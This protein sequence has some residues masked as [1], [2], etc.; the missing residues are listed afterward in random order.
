MK[1][2][3]MLAFIATQLLSGCA[4][5]SSVHRTLDTT[6]GQGVL[7]DIKQRAIL[8]SNRKITR[9]DVETTQTVVCAEPSPDALSAYAL[10]L[11]AKA[12]DA[13]GK[14]ISVGMGSS[15]SSAYV[16]LRTQSIQLLRD[17]FFRACEAYMNNAIDAGEYNLLI[18]RYQK[19]TAALL[20]IEQL[21]TIVSVPR[22]AVTATGAAKGATH[23]FLQTVYQSN[24]EKLA[25]VEKNLADPKIT[26]DLKKS[27]TTEA[28]RLK[29]ENAQIVQTLTSGDTGSPA[30]VATA[31][32]GTKS[33][34]AAATGDAATIANVVQHIVDNITQTDDFLQLCVL[35]VGR[36][37]ASSAPV[38]TN[39][40]G[41]NGNIPGSMR[42]ACMS[43]MGLANDHLRL[44]VKVEEAIME[45]VLKDASLNAKEKVVQLRILKDGSFVRDNTG[46]ATRTVPITF[47]DVSTGTAMMSLAIKPTDKELGEILR[48]RACDPKKAK[49]C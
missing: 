30:S 40:I 24:T 23:T 47:S 20:A 43:R 8:A 32:E 15:E 38:R 18:R 9:N 22:S 2:T 42:D 31:A 21:T 25:A 12:N 1:S 3:W 16:G 14:A 4:N 5:F 41:R 35:Q 37:V 46:L 44:Q 34:M 26:D 36:E 27:G 19:Q 7:I 11:A 6:N 17:Q 13:S 39:D 29:K 28:E 45:N 49:D 10:D 33:T 48:N